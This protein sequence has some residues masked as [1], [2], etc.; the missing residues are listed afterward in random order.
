MFTN[1]HQTAGRKNGRFEHTSRQIRIGDRVLNANYGPGI[2]RGFGP[3]GA[4]VVRF[5]TQKTSRSVFPTF[6]ERIER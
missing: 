5:D 4:L 2:V 1:H 6:L 3:D